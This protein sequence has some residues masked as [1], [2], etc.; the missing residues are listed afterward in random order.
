MRAR[1][2][3]HYEENTERH[4]AVSAA[5]RDQNRERLRLAA[6]VY[7]AENSQTQSE[8]RREYA[9]AHPE[10]Q[11]AAGRRWYRRNRV[12]RQESIAKYRASR[13]DWAAELNRQQAHRRRARLAGAQVVPFSSDQLA[14]RVAYYGG[15]CWICRSAAFAELD[16]VKPISA[17][18]PHMLANL[19]PACRSCNAS[20]NAQWPY[21]LGVEEV[22]DDG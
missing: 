22:V 6:K 15:L 4:R 9:K 19:R 5:W 7:Y 1:S 17:G 20:K 13:P 10:V 18:G 21:R 11:R 12:A 8:R 3:L 2:R 14:A 16:H